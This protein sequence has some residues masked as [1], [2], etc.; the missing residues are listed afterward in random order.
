MQLLIL[1]QHNRGS[2][3]YMVFGLFP[4]SGILENRRH[5]VS[6]T[7]FVSVLRWRGGWETPTQL[8]ILERAL[9][10][11]SL[12]NRELHVFLFSRHW[13]NQT[14]YCGLSGR[15]AELYTVG[16]RFRCR[17]GLRFSVVFLSRRRSI[18][19]CAV[20]A[21]PHIISKSFYSVT[22]K[23]LVASINKLQTKITSNEKDLSGLDM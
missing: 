21:S 4:S 10:N 15:A 1:K 3:D 16:V 18:W 11:H 12:Y 9:L 8:G 14:E 17:P 19:N 23:L 20:I 22:S 13:S 7:G 5:D 2:Q 6:E